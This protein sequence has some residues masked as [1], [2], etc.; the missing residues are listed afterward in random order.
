M[1]VSSGDLK[2]QHTAYDSLLRKYGAMKA[3][4]YESSLLEPFVNEVTKCGLTSRSII[5]NRGYYTRVL[6]QKVAIQL[7]LEYTKGFPKVQVLYLG[8]GLDLSGVELAVT[9][10]DNIDQ[11]L[12][13]FEIDF[14]EIIQ[15]KYDILRKATFP[16]ISSQERLV[17]NE[18][19]RRIEYF[20]NSVVFISHDLRD[21][22]GLLDKMKENEFCCD[23]PTIII[24]ECVFAYMEETFVID[25]I[26]TIG[27]FV[28]GNSIWFS[29][30]MMHL[31]DPYGDMMFKNLSRS[32]F[33]VPGLV[34]FPTFDSQS[35]RFSSQFQTDVSQSKSAWRVSKS[36]SML[37][38]YDHMIS[39]QEKSR[40][41]SIEHLDE[42]EE[43]NMIM[44]HY[45]ITLA[46]KELCE[47]TRI[48]QK[49]TTISNS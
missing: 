46:S 48:C 27:N 43:W 2:T 34:Q 15:H 14:P 10:N 49:M 11:D 29:Y 41:E 7:F 3:G 20:D 12:S 5:L 28:H 45:C 9:M 4:Y 38:Y 35:Y 13:I 6:C 24:T 8:A 42:M 23:I 21:S 47:T 31:Q 17:V 22:L 37:D 44:R 1:A 18:N 26:S 40:V 25:L 19:K 39:P 16:K 36:I 33:S 30:D 32:G